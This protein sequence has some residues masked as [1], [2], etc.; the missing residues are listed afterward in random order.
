MQVLTSGDRRPGLVLWT[1]MIVPSEKASMKRS[2]FSRSLTMDLSL[3]TLHSVTIA[4]GRI[5][6]SEGARQ[7]T[8][9]GGT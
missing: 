5:Y 7:Q 4:F 6:T 8:T 1:C 3:S 9:I 2:P